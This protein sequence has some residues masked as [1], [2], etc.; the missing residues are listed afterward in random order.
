MLFSLLNMKFLLLL[1]V[2]FLENH[3]FKSCATRVGFLV[4]VVDI[5]DILLIREPLRWGECHFLLEIREGPI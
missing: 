1:G 3:H 2:P 4:L 5:D